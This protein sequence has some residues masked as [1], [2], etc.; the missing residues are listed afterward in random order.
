MNDLERRFNQQRQV[1]KTLDESHDE[2]VIN[3]TSTKDALKKGT[4][5]LVADQIYDKL[6]NLFNNTRRKLGI[7]KGIPIA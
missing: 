6:T 2:T 1:N 7:L 5:Y 4:T 3:M